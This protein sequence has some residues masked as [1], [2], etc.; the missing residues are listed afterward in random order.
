[1]ST[2]RTMLMMNTVA[3]MCMCIMCCTHY[4]MLS[5]QHIR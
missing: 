5:T 1:M 3:E 2:E 4:K